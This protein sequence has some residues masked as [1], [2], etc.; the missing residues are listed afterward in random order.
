MSHR[1]TFNACGLIETPDSVSIISG[2]SADNAAET[3]SNRFDENGKFSDEFIDSWALSVSSVLAN[4]RD[5]LTE[6]EAKE[7]RDWFES[8]GI[9]Y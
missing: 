5:Y 4:A 8:R 6:E 2:M 1:E 9:D 3:V 7:A